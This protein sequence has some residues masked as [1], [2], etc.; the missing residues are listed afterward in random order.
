M[1]NLAA[2]ITIGAFHVFAVVAFWGLGN[3]VNAFFILTGLPTVCSGAWVLCVLLEYFRDPPV[4]PILWGFLVGFT[5]L[6]AWF[7]VSVNL[8]RFAFAGTSFV[9]LWAGW[10][11]G[12]PGGA[13]I[14]YSV[15]CC[16]VF[17]ATFFLI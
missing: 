12:V 16:A 5:V 7:D 13:L 2:W 15:Y 10:F 1:S 9:T 8:M 6:W 11:H 17:V 3:N 4:I 14:R